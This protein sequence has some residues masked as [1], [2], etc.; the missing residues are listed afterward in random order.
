MAMAQAQPPGPLGPG[1]SEEEEKAASAPDAVADRTVADRTVDID[2]RAEA[3]WLA[4]K[5]ALVETNGD[6]SAAVEWL[7]MQPL[8]LTLTPPPPPPPS[9]MTAKPAPTG[10]RSAWG[11][12]GCAGTYTYDSTPLGRDAL[13]PYP[14]LP[15]YPP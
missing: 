4:A 12:V 7:R 15:P 13:N 2:T 14:P 11:C 8:E 9:T 1:P 5:Q 10:E 3:A 6:L